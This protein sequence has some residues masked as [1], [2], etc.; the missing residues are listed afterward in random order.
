ME[1]EKLLCSLGI[2]PLNAELNPI[3][4][5]LALLG[6]HH[7]I[8]VGRIRFTVMFSFHFIPRNPKVMQ[9]AFHTFFFF[10]FLTSINLHPKMYL[11]L[12]AKIQQSVLMN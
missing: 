9:T 2:N 4:H 12:E 1:T 3:C 8:H 7:I 11:K 10:N 5:L 6:A